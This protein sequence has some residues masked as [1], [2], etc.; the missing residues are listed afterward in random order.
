MAKKVRITG[1]T[2]KIRGIDTDVSD[3][4]FDLVEDFKEG[5]KGGFVTVDGNSARG[6]P[7]RNIKV[8]CEEPGDVYEVDAEAV[9]SADDYNSNETDEEIIERMRLRFNMLNDMARAAKKGD[10]RALLVTGPPGVGKSHG[11]EQVLSLYDT[12]EAMTGKKK[13][14]MCKG[15]MSALGLYCKLYKMK[16]ADN[17]LVFDDC[18]SVFFDDTSLNILKAALDSKKSRRISWNTDS[19]KLTEEGIPDTFEFKG[20]AIFITNIKFEN[21]RSKKLKDHLEALKSRC[22]I[23]D[24][25]I[26][27]PRE[28]MLR[29]KQIVGDGMLHEY[30]L[31]EGVDEEIVEF[32]SDNRERLQELSLRTVIKVAEL[33]KAFPENWEAYAENTVMKRKAL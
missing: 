15:A 4:I 19:R 29:I 20:S 14:E 18:D 16:E 11:I 7:E 17:I 32:V 3:V 21:I 24:L 33:A 25:T 5:T 13:Y 2:Y 31:A 28:I 22:H 9:R 30:R 27:T 12:E 8:R 1:G 6:F 26:N 10:V 23:M